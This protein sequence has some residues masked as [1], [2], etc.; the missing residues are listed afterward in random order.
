MLL[1]YAN[2]LIFMGVGAFFIV[3]NLTLGSLFRPSNPSPEKLSTYECG[4][5]P[6]GGSWIQFN[7]RFYVVALDFIIF[8]VEVVLLYPWAVVAQQF[9]WYGF[10]AMMVFVVI[11]LVGLAFAWKKGTLEWVKPKVEQFRDV[12]ARPLSQTAA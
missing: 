7:V 8:D 1:D 11:L 12:I 3:F 4:E 2:V 9:G 5:E 6:V 10:A